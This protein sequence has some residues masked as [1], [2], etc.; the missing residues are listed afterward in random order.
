MKIVCRRKWWQV[1]I[2]KRNFRD[3]KFEE[4]KLFEKTRIW[5]IIGKLGFGKLF[6]KIKDEEM[7]ES[8]VA[9]MVAC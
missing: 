4:L 6:L 1:F 3:L 8:H 5:K 7:E 2:E 9:T